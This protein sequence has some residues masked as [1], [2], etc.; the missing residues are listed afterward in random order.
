MFSAVVHPVRA[1]R[2][3]DFARCSWIDAAGNGQEN[4]AR[5]LVVRNLKRSLKNF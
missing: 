3:A 1:M 2:F 4:F 5:V